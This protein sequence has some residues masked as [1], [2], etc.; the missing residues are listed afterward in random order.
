MKYGFWISSIL[1]VVACLLVSVNYA[2]FLG[3]WRYIGLLGFVMI[4]FFWNNK[5]ITD[6]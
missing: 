4:G 6:D 5:V 3:S 2:T 1:M